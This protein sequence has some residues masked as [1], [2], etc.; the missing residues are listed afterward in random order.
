MCLEIILASVYKPFSDEVGL[1]L[2]VERALQGQL[3]KVFIPMIGVPWFSAHSRD[4][5]RADSFR[6]TFSSV[7]DVFSVDLYF[8]H[9]CLH[10]I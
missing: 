1:S 3:L 6:G 10:I 9:I 4:R 5:H 8:C 7:M 2:V